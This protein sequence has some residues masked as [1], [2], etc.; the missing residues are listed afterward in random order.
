MLSCSDADGCRYSWVVEHMFSIQSPWISS[1]IVK[2]L[3]SNHAFI[4][5]EENFRTFLSVSLIIYYHRMVLHKSPASLKFIV[6]VFF[7]LFF[8]V[9]SFLTMDKMI[10]FSNFE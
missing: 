2:P 4:Y 10:R 5:L 3:D 8:E 7:V 1:T 9:H 6:L